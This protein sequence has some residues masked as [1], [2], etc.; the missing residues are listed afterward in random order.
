VLAVVL[1]LGAAVCWGTGDFLGGL[2]S[3][4]SPI[5]AVLAVTMPTGLVL[6]AVVLLVVRPDPPSAS[7]FAFA[8]LA[9]VAGLGGLAALYRGLSRGAMS[10]VAPLSAT[11]P[12]V[13]VV[14]GVAR[15]E[16]PSWLQAAGIVLAL[17]GIVLVSRE[18]GPRA[19]VA[20]GAGLGVLAA[21]GFGSFFVSLDAASEEGALWPTVVLRA[22]ATLVILV[23]ALVLRPRIP[24]AP[25]A[26]LP[27]FAIGAIDMIANGLFAAAS[28]RGLVSIVSVLASL[29]PAVVVALAA[30]VLHER[31]HR[32]QA[33]G[34]AAALA[35]A[36]LISVG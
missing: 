16:R 8:A 2:A 29:Y 14:V 15:G 25:A 26:L 24:R 12:I 35:G 34:A 33:L 4:R 6:A 27:L 32:V 5:V 23:L 28:S 13:P 36:A 18:A 21:L 9:G 3:R 17:C 10:V 7:S 30:V 22:S 11:A 31:M 19:G 20:A 1:A